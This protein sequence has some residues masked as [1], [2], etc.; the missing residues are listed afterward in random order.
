MK[1]VDFGKNY[2]FPLEIPYVFG[3]QNDMK[4]ETILLLCFKYARKHHK[5]ALALVLNT[6]KR[7]IQGQ[8]A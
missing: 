1:K 7:I 3:S 6:W 5:E 8:L 4:I 2:N